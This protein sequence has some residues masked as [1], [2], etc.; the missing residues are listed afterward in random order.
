MKKLLVLLFI[1]IA[2]LLSV[3]QRPI[4]LNFDNAQEY[5]KFVVPDGRTLTIH[6][7]Y[8]DADTVKLKLTIMKRVITYG[9]AGENGFTKSLTFTRLDRS[10]FTDRGLVLP[11][12][13]IIEYDG[14]PVILFCTL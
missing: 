12:R 5:N 10:N 9:V 14:V 6:S 13:A 1:V 11:E 7:I 2:P 3:A 4:V 8:S